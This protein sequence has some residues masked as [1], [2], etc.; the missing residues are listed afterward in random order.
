MRRSRMHR[1][2]LLA[3]VALTGLVGASCTPLFVDSFRLSHDELEG[4]DN[5]TAGSASARAYIIDRMEGFAVGIDDQQVGDAAY[6]QPFAAG[7]N[8]LGVI[9]GTD[10]ADEYVMVGAH[11]DHL[12]SSCDLTVPGDTICNGATDNAA[13]AAA[14]LQVGRRIASL[15]D[16]PRRSVILAFWDAEEDGLLGSLHYTQNP[17]VPLADTIAYVNFDILGA[18]LLPSLRESTFAIGAES[19]GAALTGPLDNAISGRSL[20]TRSLSAVF[21]QGR[22]DYQNF[23]NAGVPTVFFTD[24]TGPCYH[25]VE[26]EFAVIDHSKLFRQALIATQ[27]TTDLAN[28]NDVPTFTQ[29]PTIANFDDAVALSEVA[30]LALNDID[31]FTVEQQ[32]QLQQIASDLATIVAEGEENFDAA[33]INTLLLSALTA[34]NLLTTGEC[35]GFLAND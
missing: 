32:A 8:V 31:R 33:D 4:R 28:T 27:L 14:V 22:S 23:L 21:G 10:L 34:V 13:G 35:D 19:G 12:G 11:Y 9:P 18:N 5:N 17:L 3:L 29:P 2:R 7:T 16:G 24:S 20:T 30:S 6:E 25:T 1:L 26:D 15:P